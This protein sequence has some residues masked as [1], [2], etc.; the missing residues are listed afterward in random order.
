MDIKTEC[1]KIIFNRTDASILID[2]LNNALLNENISTGDKEY[3]SQLRMNVQTA[4]D[5]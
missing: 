4:F 3:A 2:V 5:W 1:I